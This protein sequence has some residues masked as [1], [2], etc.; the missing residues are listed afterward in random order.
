[1]CLG[2]TFGFGE[3]L[4]ARE[5]YRACTHTH[6]RA[7][8]IVIYTHNYTHVH[9]YHMQKGVHYGLIIIYVV[10]MGNMLIILT[11]WIA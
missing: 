11:L 6:S 4:R 9:S 3:E 2:S 1:M 8:L 7:L 10:V 5:G